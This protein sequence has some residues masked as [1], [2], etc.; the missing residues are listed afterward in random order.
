MRLKDNLKNF[1]QYIAR[2]FNTFTKK[3]IEI[4]ISDLFTESL[5]LTM[6]TSGN[7]P[8]TPN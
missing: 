7:S 6:S 5:S 8:V 4:A 2:V 1:S 3:V